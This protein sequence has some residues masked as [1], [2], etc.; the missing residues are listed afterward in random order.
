MIE[1]RSS[2]TGVG[3][4]HISAGSSAP[5]DQ[6]LTIGL[7]NNMPDAALSATARQF[8][9]LLSVASGDLRIH[10]RLFSIP[11]LS[12]SE[13]G[14]AHIKQNYEDIGELWSSDL[15]GLIVT[16]AE[17][18]APL[19]EDE[20]YWN[21]LTNIVDW[22]EDHATSSVWSCLA[23]HA[24]VLHLDRIRRKLLPKKLSGVF[25]C[26]KA[27]EH[28]IVEGRPRQ[29]HVPH[30]RY[31]GLPDVELV[32]RGYRILSKSIEAGT[33][34]FVRERKS[35]FIF[36]QG[37]P[38]YARDALLREYLRDI[39]RFIAGERD[40]YPDM[41]RGY[42]DAEM[43]AQFEE[44][45]REGQ[46]TLETQPALDL[47]AIATTLP[48]TWREPAIGLYANWLSYLA[49]H[50]NAGSAKRQLSTLSNRAA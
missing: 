5:E 17:P 39:R 48:F 14:R 41:P 34:I 18:R 50:R 45:R 35:L 10:L 44:L 22:A 26:F 37:H 2:E 24:A 8:H 33:D 3:F 29:W 40:T 42:F 4:S 27:E 11:E 15:D 19:L 38:E 49:E 23:A 30:S 9:E 32:D 47:A 16:G 46:G 31:N 21:T 6:C 25:E 20:P 13:A 12:R 7:V 28:R 1:T 36:L 43:T